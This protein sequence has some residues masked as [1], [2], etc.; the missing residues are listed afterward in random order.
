LW[1]VS[2]FPKGE[3]GNYAA[4]IC[5]EA[6][7][8]REITGRLASQGL[9]GIISESG[10]WVFLDSFGG[11]EQIPL[12][13][14]STR[15]LPFDPRNDGY[16]D[17]LRPLFVQDGQR[18]IYIPAGTA[19]SHEKRIAAVM[20]DISYTIEYTG[21]GAGGTGS[22]GLLL[23]L[24]AIASGAFFVIRPLRSALMPNAAGLIPCLPVLAPLVIG[25]AAGFILAALLAGFAVIIAGSRQNP[26]SLPHRG[27]LLHW[28]LPYMLI[29]GYGIVVLCSGLPVLF[30]LAVFALF[31][32]MFT[33][34]QKNESGG[35]AGIRG[36]ITA[37]IPGKKTTGG[38]T[39]KPL[40]SP[41]FNRRMQGH[42]RFSPVMI[43]NRKIIRFDFA[44]AMIPFTISALVLAFAGIVMPGA[45]AIITDV[46]LLPSGIQITE[47]DYHSHYLFQSTFSV[48]PLHRQTASAGMSSFRL[49]SDGLPELFEL[50]DEALV[51]DTDIPPFPLTHLLQELNR[52]KTN[53]VKRSARNSMVPEIVLVLLPL[54]FII[55]CLIRR[56]YSG[57]LIHNS[58]ESIFV[59]P[60]GAFFRRPHRST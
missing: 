32:G 25:G 28:F 39:F 12:D 16:A 17:M 49:A 34:S 8:D 56:S 22:A 14:F 33:F 5:N 59:S 1:G 44:W 45:P 9:T 19:A 18:F 35:Q 4:I 6:I 60:R 7:P 37:S 51:A 58:H 46:S 52:E 41:L 57:N 36:K 31:F 42:Q 15:L 23:L 47:A 40:K 10:Q 20:G 11:I 43:L 50:S 55:P 38:K 53:I 29:A 30:C 24:F 54:F 3:R 27:E 21:T 48:R 2:L 13:E 26:F